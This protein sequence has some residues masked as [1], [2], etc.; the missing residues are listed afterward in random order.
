MSIESRNPAPAS[1]GDAPPGRT[2]V[3]ALRHRD[4][5][6]YWTGSVISS[7][8]SQFTSVAIAWQ[9]YEITNSPLQLG[10]I[11]LARGG[12]TLVLLLFGGLLADAI[13]RRKLMMLTQIGQMCVSASLV[14]CTFAGVISPPVL[15]G[16]SVLLALFGSFENPARQA[17][18][19]NLVPRHELTNALALNSSQRQVATIV[20]PS[21]AGLVLAAAGPV[22]CYAV[23]ASSWLAMLAAL[24][25]MRPTAQIAAGRRAVS[26]QSLRQGLAFVW[27]HPVILSLMALDFG[28]NFFGNSRALLPIYARDILEVGPQGLGLLYTATSFGALGMAAFISVRPQVRRAG[29]CVLASVAVYGVFMALFAISHTFWLSFLML[30][31]AGASNSLSN[32]LRGT[33]N[34]LITPDELRGRVTS[35]NSMFTNTGPQLGQFE[36]GTLASVVGAE[37]ATLAGGLFVGALAVGLA[38]GTVSVRRFE[39]GA[40][41][42]ADATPAPDRAVRV[43]RT[44]SGVR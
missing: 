19:P 30:A 41:H 9:I 42:R 27:A 3:A 25:I 7:I 36:A 1:P 26:L 29:M 34:Q 18:V 16:A 10:L 37:G 40:V 22:L 24:L 39:I 44:G 21:L 33:I 17:M 2:P 8:G 6:T 23:D 12:P 11:G 31:G 43:E 28:Q 14:L 5:R 13:N 32:V 4:F 15:Y 35:V 20:G 38:T